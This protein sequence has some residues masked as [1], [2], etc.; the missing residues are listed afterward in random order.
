M[1]AQFICLLPGIEFI[2][3]QRKIR[4]PEKK[5]RSRPNSNG[6]P[7]KFLAGKSRKDK[8]FLAS[9]TVNAE[10]YRLKNARP[11]G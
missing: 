8:M 11:L 6:M 10:P 5:R 1:F 2:Y 7:L 9:H 4:K 3:C